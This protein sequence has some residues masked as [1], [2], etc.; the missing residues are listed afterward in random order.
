MSAM[1]ETISTTTEMSNSVLPRLNDS[2]HSLRKL[3]SSNF[4]SGRSTPL[5]SEIVAN[6]VSCQALEAAVHNAHIDRMLFGKSPVPGN[7]REDGRVYPKEL[8]NGENSI[9][10]SLQRTSL[11]KTVSTKEQTMQQESP[12]SCGLVPKDENDEEVEESEEVSL[13]SISTSNCTS[14]QSSSNYTV[15]VRTRRR[16]RSTRIQESQRDSTES[17]LESSTTSATSSLKADDG[18]LHSESSDEQHVLESTPVPVY[19]EESN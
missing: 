17:P 9:E 13:K 5:I 19:E 16:S 7:N 2:P 4:T 15:E 1:N 12:A 6:R 14:S 18:S 8:Y 3:N 11:S 10:N